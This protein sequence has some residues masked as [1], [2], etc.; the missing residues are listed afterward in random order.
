MFENASAELAAF[1]ISYGALACISFAVIRAE[2]AK[3]DTKVEGA[4]RPTPLGELVKQGI[5]LSLSGFAQRVFRRGDIVVV[6]A[7][8]GEGAVGIYRAA[9]T[10]SSGVEQLVS[11]IR[12]FALHNMGKSYG[13]RRDQEVSQHY[14]ASVVLG[15]LVALP[16]TVLLIILSPWIIETLNDLRI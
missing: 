6:G 16:I 9:Y 2:I 7:L 5:S 11:P 15:A 14:E 1:G 10:M 13:A 3:A 12:S 4:A 8:L